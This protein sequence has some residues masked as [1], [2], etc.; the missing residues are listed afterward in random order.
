MV[1][2]DSNPLCKEAEVHYYDFILGKGH[3]L[4]QS[5]LLSILVNARTAKSN[6]ID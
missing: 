5:I 3:E 4:I 6:L 1:A 2:T